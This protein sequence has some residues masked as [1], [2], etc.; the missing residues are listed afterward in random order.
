MRKVIKQ[1]GEKR[2]ATNYLRRLLQ[3]NLDALVIDNL[4]GWKHGCP[5]PSE[6]WL[7]YMK[8]PQHAVK[9]MSPDLNDPEILTV[10]TEYRWRQKCTRE[11]TL[12][13]KP[14]P[15][16]KA[17]I[18]AVNHGLVRFT[19]S[20]RDPFAWLPAV[21]DYDYQWE[22]DNE[23]LIQKLVQRFNKRYRAWRAMCSRL[24][25]HAHWAVVRHEDLLRDPIAEIER[26]RTQ[27]K[28]SLRKGVKTIANEDAEVYSSGKIGQAYNSRSHNTKYYLDR[29]YLNR[30]TGDSMGIAR[31]AFDWDVLDWLGYTP[32][33]P[34]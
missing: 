24:S 30:Y 22:P 8:D 11:R 9:P 1:Y 4:L 21:A 17:C 20:I 33:G 23:W 10:E 32:E 19:I 27:F 7:Q 3:D 13:Q 26:L 18:Q 2:T 29:Q 15:H 25:R 6:V 12:P 14:K 5:E 34:K 28:I 16:L 31:D